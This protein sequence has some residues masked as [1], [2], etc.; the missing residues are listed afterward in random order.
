[1]RPIG[2]AFLLAFGIG[3]AAHED[4]AA[5]ADA[6]CWRHAYETAA[7]ELRDLEILMLIDGP[8]IAARTGARDKLS[9]LRTERI[10]DGML[11]VAR[12]AAA[13]GAS[14]ECLSAHATN[15]ERLRAAGL[16]GDA[17]D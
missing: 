6:L 12:V 11:D 8:D 3:T 17:S 7:N 15:R 13:N 14:P 5:K 4:V 1:M 16:L 2:L 9:T 10:L